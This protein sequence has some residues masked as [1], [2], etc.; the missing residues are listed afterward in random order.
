M[1]IRLMAMVAMMAGLACAE[2]WRPVFV[3]VD[4]ALPWEDYKGVTYG[5]DSDSSARGDWHAALSNQ[6]ETF[7]NAAS[8]AALAVTG[9]ATNGGVFTCTN[10]T[11]GAGEWRGYSKMALVPAGMKTT[12]SVGDYIRWNTS[13]NVNVGAM[14]ATEGGITVTRDGT[15]LVTANINFNYVPTNA[16]ATIGIKRSG[17]TIA[18]TDYLDRQA[19]NSDIP[20]SISGLDTTTNGAVYRVWYYMIGGGATTTNTAGVTGGKLNVIELP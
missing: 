12:N 20:H 18:T 1:K 15:Y 4:A 9:G 3:D 5:T 7:T 16:L 2:E 10:S 19:G 13:P 6:F 14:T 11:T 17:T 8:V